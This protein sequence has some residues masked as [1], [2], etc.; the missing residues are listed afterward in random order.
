MPIRRQWMSLHC[1]A[2]NVNHQ[3]VQHGS[4]AS[5]ITAILRLSSARCLQDC[6]HIYRC[7]IMDLLEGFKPHNHQHKFCLLWIKIDNKLNAKLG[8]LSIRTVLIQPPVL[9]PHFTVSSQGQHSAVITCLKGR[10]R[11]TTPSGSE[12]TAGE[13]SPFAISVCF[14]S[15]LL[16]CS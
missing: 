4:P 2:L 3:I 12:V 9:G 5:L 6:Q 7:K 13:E 11:W 8:Q 1:T 14:C 16:Y 10:M 15:S